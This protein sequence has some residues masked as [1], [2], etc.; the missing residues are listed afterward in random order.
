MKKLQF[1]LLLFIASFTKAQTNT[2]VVTSGGKVIGVFDNINAA[3]VPVIKP[4]DVEGSPYLS[5]YWNRGTVVFRKGKRADSILLKFDIINN[6][7]Y[8]EQD[9]L[10]MKFIDEVSSFQFN[11]LDGQE[12]KTASFKN[13]YPDEGAANAQSFYQVITEGNSYHLLKY[14]KRIISEDYVY[15]GVAKKKYNVFDSWFVYDVKEK[16]LIQVKPGKSSITKKLTKES[17]RIEDLSKKN[18][19]ELKNEAELKALFDE[20]NKS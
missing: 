5:D 7:L 18:G 10:V 2:S 8:F 15:G 9:N 1:L 4:N 20:L 19:W 3:V 11:Y 14:L 12:T 6:S 16:K 17:T 13:G